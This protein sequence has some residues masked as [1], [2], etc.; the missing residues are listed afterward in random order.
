MIVKVRWTATASGEIELD[1][2]D[3]E[4]M[5]EDEIKYHAMDIAH[6]QG[7]YAIQLHWPEE[8]SL[9]MLIEASK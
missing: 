6:E 9:E 1:S 3:L 2:G 5:S 4:G 7:G 8:D